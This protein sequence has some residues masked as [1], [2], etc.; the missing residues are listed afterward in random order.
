MDI[1]IKSRL[2]DACRKKLTDSGL[3]LQQAMDDLQQQSNEYGAPKDRYDP[4]KTQLL[5]R[6]DMLAQQLAKE[7]QDLKIL[8]KIDLAIPCTDVRFG[9]LV[10]TP[11]YNYFIAVGLG[12]IVIADG[13]FYAISMQVP[14]YEAF[15]GKKAGD[16]IL[17][18]GKKIEIQEVV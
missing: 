15:K 18:R 10:M 11:D 4:F 13:V 14:L 8:D 2:V 3:N 6:R 16:S 5:R 1:A 9:A 7:L 17:F 12:K